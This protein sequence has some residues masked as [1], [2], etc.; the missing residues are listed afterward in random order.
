MNFVALVGHGL[1]ALSV[2]SEVI[3][4]RLLVAIC[5]FVGLLCALLATVIFVRLVTA[6]AIP[7]WATT[8]VGLL[9]VL[10]FQAVALA[11]FFVLL[12]MHGRTQPHFIP[13]R[14]YHVFV[15]P[16]T[17]VFPPRPDGAR[18]APPSSTR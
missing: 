4:V 11:L 6:L 17:R 10:L 2:H 7:G 13:I 5:V 1:S 18:T 14:D 15:N 16:V 9:V 12:I 3:G 8:A